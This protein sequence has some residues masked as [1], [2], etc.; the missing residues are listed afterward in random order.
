MKRTVTVL[1][2]LTCALAWAAAQDATTLQVTPSDQIKYP[3]A[4]QVL[5]KTE[6]AA[7][8][9]AT[10]ATAP[11]ATATPAASTP[12]PA[13]TATKAS[14]TAMPATAR[15]PT[16]PVA[17]GL[18]TAK[19]LVASAPIPAAPASTPRPAS[20]PAS[21]TADHGWFLKWTITGDE[22]SA[23]GW[24]QALGLGA[25]LHP[26]AAGTWEVWAG[27]LD[28]AAL[29]AVLKGQGGVATLVRR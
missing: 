28:A 12:A 8:A 10:P 3:D 7:P 1:I 29:G 25:S 20:A 4:S 27:P 22:T 19:P 21:V 6:P 16:S 13:A 11:A 23:L 15:A 17:T 26:L 18:P 2:L 14:D 24:V 9:A 5:N